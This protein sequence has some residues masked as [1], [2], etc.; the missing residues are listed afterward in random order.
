[1][2]RIEGYVN[3]EAL[4]EL[5]VEEALKKIAPVCRKFRVDICEAYKHLTGKAVLKKE[6]DNLR[7]IIG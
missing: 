2:K 5:P 1:M 4:R 6:K 3:K 7:K